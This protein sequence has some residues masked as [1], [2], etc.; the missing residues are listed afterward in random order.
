MMSYRDMTYCGF[1]EVCKSGVGC[2]RALTENIK[3]SAKKAEMYISQFVNPPKH[4]FIP[5]E[6]WNGNTSENSPT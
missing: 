4:C 2:P 5:K 1:H 3:E 6:N